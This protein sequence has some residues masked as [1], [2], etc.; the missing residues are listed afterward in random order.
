VKTHLRSVAYWALA[1]LVSFALAACAATNPY[2]DPSKKHH[3]PSGF[4]NNY[5]DLAG[6]PFN[7]LIKWRWRAWRD[8]VPKPPSQI[9]K[10]YQFEL[11]QPDLAAMRNATADPSKVAVTWIG[12]ATALVQ[13]GG[14]SIL[15][16]PH[17]SERA[18]P[19]SF[20]G[21]KRKTPVP[22]TLA[23]LPRI[24]VVL[25][26]HNHFDHLDLTTVKQ[27]IAQPGDQPLFVV[28]LGI[29]RWL[30]AQGAKRVVGLDWWQQHELNKVQFHLTPVQHWCSRGLFDRNESLW[31]GWVVKTPTYQWFFAGDTGYSK[32]FRDIF[33]RF[34]VFDLALIPIGAYQPRW[35]MQDQH[36]DPAEA[37]KI[38][39]DIRSR[40]SIG[41]HW[42]TFELTD[43]ALDQP[44]VDLPV[45]LDAAKVAPD[46]FMTL[47]HG[48]TMVL[49]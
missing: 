37:V 24:D 15:T 43:E 14:L 30:T 31:G 22:T 38:H 18:S 8:D 12:H 35:F 33:D 25:I 9:V 17:F 6:K 29:D 34:G 1:A 26:S 36:V 23:Q 39:Q 40:F 28:P 45:A 13:T 10:G 32:D 5:V 11:R 4:K 3:T 7:E 16:D 44:L 46:Q 21:P 41:I 49:R 20:A 47:K 42:G 2:F 27:L 19:V 48:Q